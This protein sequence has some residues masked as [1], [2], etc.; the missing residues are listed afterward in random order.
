MNKYVYLKEHLRYSMTGVRLL[1]N[2]F[3]EQQRLERHEVAGLGMV[4]LWQPMTYSSMCSGSVFSTSMSYTIF[5]GI[6]HL[7]AANPPKTIVGC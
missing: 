2:H 5:S 1:L 6:S 4:T 7:F 3:E